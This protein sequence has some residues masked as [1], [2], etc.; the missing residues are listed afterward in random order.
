MSFKEFIMN[1][2]VTPQLDLSLM[3]KNKFAGKEESEIPV[4]IDAL[5]AIEKEN[6]VFLGAQP[7]KP[8]YR[9]D[10]TFKMF[11]SVGTD[12]TI[13]MSNKEKTYLPIVIR[14]GT[15]KSHWLGN[16]KLTEPLWSHNRKYFIISLTLIS[17]KQNPNDNICSYRYWD[18]TEPED[19]FEWKIETKI[20]V[21]E[22]SE[23]NGHECL[24]TERGDLTPVTDLETNFACHYARVLVNEHRSDWTRLPL[25]EMYDTDTYLQRFHTVAKSG[26]SY[27]EDKFNYIFQPRDNRYT[28][29]TN[30]EKVTVNFSGH[31]KLPNKPN[32]FKLIG[33]LWSVENNL[34]GV[35][36]S[37]CGVQHV[38]KL[39]PGVSKVITKATLIGGITVV[40]GFTHGFTKD[41]L[42]DVAHKLVNIY[43]IAN[44]GE[45]YFAVSNCDDYFDYKPNGLARYNVKRFLLGWELINQRPG[46]DDCGGSYALINTCNSD[47]E[48]VIDDMI[49][50]CGGR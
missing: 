32:E 48:N 28:Y 10:D 31:G 44:D 34:T 27:I 39:D 6:L 46:D 2:E 5:F 47:I 18:Y 24:T 9:L 14:P 11:S 8:D 21:S 16:E 43:I 41:T 3:I 50:L 26:S 17:T 12:I 33:L 7:Y 37:I 15:L 45:R 1:A 30:G 23:I 49:T 38:Y 4:G 25:V 40:I 29:H 20:I 36:A 22:I 42:Y 35:I 19:A 13:N